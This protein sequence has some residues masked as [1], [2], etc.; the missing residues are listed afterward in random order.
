MNKKC[1]T[2]VFTFLFFYVTV[3]LVYAKS[4]HMY[5]KNLITF[6]SY[7]VWPPFSQ[8]IFTFC[9]LMQLLFLLYIWFIFL[10]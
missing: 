3:A 9:M 6:S 7:M 1:I 10:G 4:G 5:H 2:T 8:V